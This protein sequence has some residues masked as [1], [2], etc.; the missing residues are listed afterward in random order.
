[1]SC[2]EQIMLRQ[3]CSYAPFV[4]RNHQ[5]VDTICP[6]RK[7]VHPRPSKGVRI[8]CLELHATNNFLRGL[9][10]SPEVRQLMLLQHDVQT[11][12]SC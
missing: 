5:S 7:L 3:I 10:S 2:Y 12:N 11:E 6:S 8:N 1:M 9:A 4:L